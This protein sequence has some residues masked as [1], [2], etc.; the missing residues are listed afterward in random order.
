M[1]ARQRGHGDGDGTQRGGGSSR[2][3]VPRAVLFF[4]SW[5]RVG[6]GEQARE[7]FLSRRKGAYVGI[8]T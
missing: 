5:P 4:M 8:S 2:G 1:A 3:V 7:P 6:E